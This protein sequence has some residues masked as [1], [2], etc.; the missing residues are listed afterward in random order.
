MKGG[1]SEFTNKREN[2]SVDNCNLRGD[3]NTL[4]NVEKYSLDTPQSMEKTDGV[5]W[6]NL[7]QECNSAENFAPIESVKKP[8]ANAY[9]GQK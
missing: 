7:K 2:I 1:K 3:R 8:H 6:R 9:R 4:G 5:I